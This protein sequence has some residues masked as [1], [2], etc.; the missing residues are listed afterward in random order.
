MKKLIYKFIT[1]SVIML[2]IISCSTMQQDVVISTIPQENI[3]EIENFEFRLAHLDAKNIITEDNDFTRKSEIKKNAEQLLS[4]LSKII[5]N[6]NIQQSAQARLNAIKGRVYLI[7][8]N[9]ESAKICYQLSESLY[10]GDIQ[11]KILGYRLGIIK[12]ISD[13]PVHSSDK[14]IILLEQAIIYF[15][16]QNYAY[17]IAKFD[18]AFISCKSYNKEAYTLLRDYAWEKHSIENLNSNSNLAAIKEL[19]IGQMMLIAQSYPDIITDYTGGNEYNEGTLFR[20][21]TQKGLITSAFNEDPPKKTYA[22][23]K[24]TKSMAARFIWN[25]FCNKK[26][27]STLKRR[28][29]D[30]PN[31]TFAGKKITSPIKDVSVTHDDFNAILCCV[32]YRFLS[33]TDG[34][35][36]R[37]NDPVSGAEIIKALNIIQEIFN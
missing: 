1:L 2:S 32:Q 19:T 6:I 35:N 23:T 14:E 15:T 31:G 34:I 21:L 25:L 27:D 5:N 16:E 28:Y 8:E 17:S 29:T 3:S 37:P 18:E 20:K 7:Q 33:L 12:N 13:I 26:N 22:Y 4:D 11:N 30:S 36:F 10:K 24:L 9:I